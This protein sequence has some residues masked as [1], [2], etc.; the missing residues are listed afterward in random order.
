MK[1]NIIITATAF[2]LI[3]AGPVG[4]QT[5]T[6]DFETADTT[7]LT[8]P[9]NSGTTFVSGTSD[10]TDSPAYDPL[11]T[12]PTTQYPGSNFLRVENS[13]G[14]GVA[15]GMFDLTA[16]GSGDI[17]ENRANYI[18]EA[19]VFVVVDDPNIRNQVGIGGRW[20]SGSGNFPFEMFYSHN[21]PG[22]SNGYG[23][24]NAGST[25]TY[26]HFN[27]LTE[28][29]NRWVRMRITFDGPTAE[30][31]VDRDRDGTYDL[32]EENITTNDQAGAPVI[33][34]VVNDPNNGHAA[35]PNRHSYFD[36]FSYTP[37]PNSSVSDWSVY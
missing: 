29:E 31:A 32:I 11:P 33:F 16:T 20:T 14:A 23:W 27:G 3:V 9:V 2:A 22:T 30:I 35:V 6:K 13:T 36:N 25:S 7:G 18:V 15:L 12:D 28:S 1:D 5:V 10:A 37:L 4:A 26:G 17:T 21:T 34:S 19:D 8:D 24:R